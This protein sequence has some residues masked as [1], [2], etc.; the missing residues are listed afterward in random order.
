MA[1]SQAHKNQGGGGSINPRTVLRTDRPL[2]ANSI[3]SKNVTSVAGTLASAPQRTK[4][5]NSP[6]TNISSG[7]TPVNRRHS[8]G[9]SKCHDGG[10]RTQATFLFY[11]KNDYVPP[12]SSR[13]DLPQ[14]AENFV[15]YRLSLTNLGV[16]LLSK[17][18][19]IQQLME[20]LWFG[21]IGGRVRS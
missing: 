14:Y 8:N 4:S 2:S 15:M 20:A 9:S 16:V 10:G 3:T 6:L 18:W 17:S 1:F 12:F 19:H 21:I 7:A 5:S 13:L 11:L